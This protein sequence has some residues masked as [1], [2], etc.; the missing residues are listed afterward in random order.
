MKT[1]HTYQHKNLQG[2]ENLVGLHKAM[3]FK[4]LSGL[5]GM[6]FMVL[7]FLLLSFFSSAQSIS[8]SVSY[9]TAELSA[10]TKK[11]FS[12]ESLMGSNR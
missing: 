5:G 2:F 10:S 7:F 12:W 6:N 3:Q 11:D 4:N 1:Q 8:N 9:S